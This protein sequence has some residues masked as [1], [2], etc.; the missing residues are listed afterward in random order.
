[1]SKPELTPQVEHRRAWTL[2]QAELNLYETSAEAFQVPLTFN[3]TVMTSM[4]VGKKIMHLRDQDPFE[5]LPGQALIMPAGE[6]M[7]IDFPEATLDAPTQCMALTISTDFIRETLETFNHYLPRLE[8]QDQWNLNDENY[9]FSQSQDLYQTLRRLLQIFRED[10][11]AK[12][13]FAINALQELLLRVMQTQ[14]RHLLIDHCESFSS[15]H[16]LAFAVSYIREHLDQA[17]QVEKLCEKACLSKAQ[18]YRAFKQEFGLSPVD[19]VNRERI[20][21]AQHILSEPGKT[22]SDACY[23]CGFNSLSYF[24]RIFKRWTGYSPTQYQKQLK[25]GTNSPM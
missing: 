3:D 1:M 22:A 8:Q 17:I 14:A 11:V 16:R 9:H 15:H 24:N 4:I 25:G 21:R 6:Q 7:S 18:F 19:F 12:D 23:A 10:H 20:R 13:Y 5:F 2:A